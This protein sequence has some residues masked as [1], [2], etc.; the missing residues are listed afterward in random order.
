M[1]IYKAFTF[2]ASHKLPNVCEGHK[3]GNIHGHTFRTE[4]H[5]SGPIDKHAGWVI[6]FT[7]I[8]KLFN[9]LLKQ[10]DHNYLNDIEGLG[11]PTSE[12]IAIWIWKQLEPELSSLKENIELKKIVVQE[13]PN[14]GA[15]YTGETN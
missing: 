6:D 14:S 15:C 4:I 9:P 11:N 13:S 12:N 1:E 3:C 7:D 8:Q 2:D 10:L 5:V